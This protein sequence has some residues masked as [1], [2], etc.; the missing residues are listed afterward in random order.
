MTSIIIGWIQYLVGWE[1]GLIVKTIYHN[2]Q[3]G[4]M[5]IPVKLDSVAEGYSAFL[6]KLGIVEIDSHEMICMGT[7]K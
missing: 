5:P 4:V 1:S 6:N 7:G 2:L 3:C